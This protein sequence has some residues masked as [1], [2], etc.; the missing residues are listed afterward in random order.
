M[1]AV[2]CHRRVKAAS[3]TIPRL[4]VIHGHPCRP[5][6]AGLDP[7]F[8]AL[9]QRRVF[10]DVADAE[11]KDV[12]IA[13]L[14]LLKLGTVWQFTLPDERGI[15]LH[16]EAVVVVFGLNSVV[17]DVAFGAQFI[18]FAIERSNTEVHNVA[19]DW[20]MDPKNHK[21]SGSNDRNVCGKHVE[22]LKG[23]NWSYLKNKAGEVLKQKWL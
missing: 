21:C 10:R 23:M 17:N 12:E 22:D 14:E 6:A 11:V 1:V 8:V 16:A 3:R 7:I 15:A 18:V 19:L 9:A 2:G 5:G 20:E 13:A 4:Y